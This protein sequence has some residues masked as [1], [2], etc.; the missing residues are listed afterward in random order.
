MKLEVTDDSGTLCYPKQDIDTA[1]ALHGVLEHISEVTR[2]Q[3]LSN[4]LTSVT[5]I[6]QVWCFFLC[7]IIVERDTKAFSQMSQG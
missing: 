3:E 4:V 1:L 6:P 5:W 2:T 7:D